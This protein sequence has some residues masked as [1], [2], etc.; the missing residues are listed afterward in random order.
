MTKGFFLGK[1]M[2]PHHGHLHVCEVARQ[3]VDQLTVLVCSHDREPID[4]ALRAEWMRACLGGAGIDVIH[5]H[6]DIPQDPSEHPDFWRI[7]QD[8]ILALHPAPIDVVFGSEP[9]VE[10]LAQVLGADPF[11]VDLDRQTVPISAT[12]IR[13]TPGAH[14]PYI[15]KPVRSFYQKRVTLLG[16]ESTGKTT[17]S[18]WLAERFST[19]VIPEFGRTYDATFRQ[20]QGWYHDDFLR[21]ADGHMLD[22][23]RI[24]PD[25]GPLVIEDTNL[26]QTAV[27]NDAL[28]GEASPLLAARFSKMRHPDLYLLMSPEM[29]WIDDG[30]RYHGDE[31]Q[32]LDFHS[33]LKRLLEQTDA[34]WVEI[35]GKT[36]EDRQN[37]A[38]LAISRELSGVQSKSGANDLR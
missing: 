10:K 27:W 4:G 22:A 18:N 25:G 19:K 32:R 36:W 8:A 35:T 9:Y 38:V 23:A 24:A 7:W 34:S 20:G 16:A 21:I 28:I 3:H 14:W 12:Q 6:R 1:F 5:M 33:G 17:L 29:A 2:P 26:L 31:K 30:T 11:F 37:A 15:P 13:T